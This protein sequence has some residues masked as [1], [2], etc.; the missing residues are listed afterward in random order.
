[1]N[2]RMKIDYQFYAQLIFLLLYA[3]LCK[4]VVVV[5]DLRAR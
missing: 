2:R 3:V 4:F 5:P 1:M